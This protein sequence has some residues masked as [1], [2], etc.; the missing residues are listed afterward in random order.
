MSSPAAEALSTTVIVVG[1]GLGELLCIL[2]PLYRPFATRAIVIGHVFAAG[3]VAAITAAQNGAKVILLEKE[4]K[5]NGNSA[6]A[7]SGINFVGMCL[8]RVV[9]G[10]VSGCLLYFVGFVAPS[11]LLGHS[12]TV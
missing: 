9:A 5:I 8:S 12:H 1:G 4:A 7:T 11:R 2:C 6:K 10:T 3:V